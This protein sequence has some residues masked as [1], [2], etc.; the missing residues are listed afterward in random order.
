M[1]Y[2]MKVESPNGWIRAKLADANFAREL[3][4]RDNLVC[5]MRCGH[6]VGYGII[7]LVVIENLPQLRSPGY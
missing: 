6:G 3:S 5:H 2:Y 4:F 1:Q 7:E